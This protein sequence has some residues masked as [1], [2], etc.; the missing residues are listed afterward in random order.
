[1]L[2]GVDKQVGE[3][4][5]LHRQS[6]YRF[7]KDRTVVDVPT[8]HP[9]CSRQHSVLQFRQTVKSGQSE[10]RPYIMDLGSVNGTFI[11]GIK[12]ETAR[13]YELLPQDC[14]KF[15]QSTREYVLLHEDLTNADN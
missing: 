12:I 11:G 1:M 9:S 4:L 7:G 3:P 10:V 13:F 14:L 2:C 5:P 15:G 8:D 6:L